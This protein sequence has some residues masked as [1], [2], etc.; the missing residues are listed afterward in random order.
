[1]WAKSPLERTRSKPQPEKIVIR[2]ADLFALSAQEGASG[3]RI[4]RC[5]P[6]LRTAPNSPDPTQ[7]ELIM[8]CSPEPGRFPPVRPLQSDLPQERHQHLQQSARIVALDVMTCI[9]DLDPASFGE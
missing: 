2:S 1:M 9:F 5:A 4:R 8:Y 7:S 6:T 3:S